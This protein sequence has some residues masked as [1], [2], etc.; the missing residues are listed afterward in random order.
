MMLQSL[1]RRLDKGKPIEKA[2]IEEIA[3]LAQEGSQQARLLARGLNPVKISAQGLQAALQELALTMQKLSGVPCSFE[4][5]PGIPPLDSETTLQVYR[6]AQEAV[7]N[8]LKHAHAHHIGL[9]L[10]YA[11]PQITLTVRDDGVGL[12]AA[13][14]T[15]GIGLRIMQYRAR[16]IG[17]TFRLQNAPGG[18]TLV[19]CTLSPNPTTPAAA[20]TAPH[21]A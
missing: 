9:R 1:A 15:E 8:A 2:E 13:E 16:M 18:G 6:I 7:N 14:P 12:P 11:A 19:T 3:M 20:S 10:S 21:P 5:D 4:R 17:A